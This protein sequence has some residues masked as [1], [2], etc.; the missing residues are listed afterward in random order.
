MSTRLCVY[1]IPIEYYDYCF[2][3]CWRVLPHLFLIFPLI[4]GERV[5]DH[6]NGLYQLSNAR[7]RKRPCKEYISYLARL[8]NIHCSELGGWFPFLIKE[9]VYSNFIR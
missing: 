1:P 2:H 7:I 6:S 8:V 3:V 4:S 5:K 9:F